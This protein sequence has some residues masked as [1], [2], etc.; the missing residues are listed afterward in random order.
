MRRSVAVMVICGCLTLGAAG[1]DH[2]WKA[3]PVPRHAIKFSPFHLLNFYP[4]IQMSYE[5]RIK[6]RFTLQVEGGYIVRRSVYRYDSEFLDKRGL[7]AKLEPRYYFGL[8]GEKSFYYG[9]LE[10]YVN[11]VNF[12]RQDSR[13]ECFDLECTRTFRRDYTYEMRYREH[14]LAAK[15]GF[16]SY[17]SQFFVDINAG[18]IVRNIRYYEPAWLEP[19][20]LAGE[21]F[22]GLKTP[23]E[24]DRL[25]MSP[26][27]GLRIGYRFR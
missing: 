6:N 5:T 11:A 24:Q 14:G 23:F 10:L 15:S 2:S 25:A 9:A 8:K 16:I 1:Q 18:L 12:D 19:E 7:K 26:A 3:D 13:V 17:F 27:L 21:F 20:V 4:T 22:P